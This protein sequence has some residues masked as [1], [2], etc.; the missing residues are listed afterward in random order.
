M[1]KLLKP[2]SKSLGTIISA[3]TQVQ[4]DLSKFTAENSE[5]INA[6][7]SQLN[8]AEEEQARAE[9]IAL[10]IQSLLK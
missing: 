10:S 6:L 7:K 4:D 1:L 3:F 2:K 5:Q 8:V 9:R